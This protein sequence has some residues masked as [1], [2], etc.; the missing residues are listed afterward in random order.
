MKKIL[1]AYDGSPGATLAI[2][3]MVRAG[4]P[5][6]AEAKV[7]TFADVWLPPSVQGRE[8]IFNER[9]D[10]RAERLH[11]KAVEELHLARKTAIEGAQLV[12][13]KF[14]IWTVS[15]SSRADSPAWGIIGEATRWRADLI[16][17]G[18][19]GRNPLEKFFLGSV[20]YKVAAEALCD[21][22]VVRSRGARAHGPSKLMIGLDGSEDARG[23]VDEVLSRSW[24]PGTKVELVT[25]IDPHLRTNILGKRDLFENPI[26]TVEDWLEPMAMELKERFES[27][28]IQ[29]QYHIFEGEPKST[30]LRQ[31]K[32]WKVDC[33]FLGARGLEHGKRQYLGTLASAICTRAH[34]T[35]EIVRHP[36]V[37]KAVSPLEVAGQSRWNKCS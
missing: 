12:H 16:V 5:E 17:I 7:I 24:R 29:V 23:A 18:S 36:S 31:A 1:I 26:R 14:P 13:S 21:V 34:C 9:A 28:E 10:L 15:N 35:V 8:N 22:R 32:E 37:R 20:S 27:K 19:H 3:D 6:N 25:A 33:I 2:E 30:I 4:L 11:E